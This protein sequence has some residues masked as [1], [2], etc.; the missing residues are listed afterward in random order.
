MV[1]IFIATCDDWLN[2][3]TKKAFASDITRFKTYTSVHLIA[4]YFILVLVMLSYLFQVLLYLT[5]TPYAIIQPLSLLKHLCVP[6]YIVYT[7]THYT[8]ILFM[9]TY[10]FQVLLYLTY[11][12]YAIIQPLSLLKHLCV[13]TYIV[14]T[15][16][17]YTFILFMHT[18]T[19]VPL[20]RNIFILFC[21]LNLFTL[22]VYY[23]C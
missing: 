22:D 2:L 19:L 23:I 1:E 3:S 14:Y 17:H 10:L 5:Y 9:H 15:L 4:L 11:T 18:L 8:F 6:T 21:H 20:N 12:P 7:L 13:P 16:T